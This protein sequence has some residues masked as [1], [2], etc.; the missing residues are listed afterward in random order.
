M[1]FKC[2][3]CGQ[4]FETERKLH[5]HLKKHDLRVA[6]YYQQYYPR[7][8]LYDGKII[9]FKSKE[10]YFKTDFNTKTNLLKWLDNL[11]EKKAKEYLKNILTQRKEEKNLLYSPCQVE[12]RSL[13]YPSIISFEKK[14][15]DYYKLCKSLGFENKYQKLLLEEGKFL[16]ATA[17]GKDS[18]DCKIYVDSREQLPLKFNLPTEKKGLK[19]GDYALSDK[20]LTCNCYIERKSLADFIST[21]SVLNHDRFCREIERA[22]ENN[23]NLIILIEDTLTHALSFPF[24]PYISK[25]IKVTPEFIFHKVR[26]MIQ[27]YDH[28]QFLFVNG[29][30]EA[31]RVI[32]KIFF[33]NCLYKKIDLQLHYDNKKL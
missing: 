29:R 22:S 5:S 23:A 19:F 14:F 20:S 31:V 15:K 27:K 3:V 9:K 28:I 4:E 32:E 16:G 11:P 33:S 26:E 25:K 17:I 8:D 2:K 12:L 13:G 6:A 21:I 30:K 10:Y 24:L 7:Y 1:S 18:E